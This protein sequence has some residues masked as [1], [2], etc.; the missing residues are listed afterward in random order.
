MP[1]KIKSMAILL[2]GIFYFLLLFI[3]TILSARMVLMTAPV[4]AP[5]E[6]ISLWY[7]LL[8][9]ALVTLFMLLLVRR[10]KTRLPFE[11]FFT[12]AIFAGI[13]FLADI[14]LTGSLG[15]IAAAAVMLLKYIY[16]R[17]WWQ[18]LV[19]ILGICGIVVSVGLSIP[20]LTA[21]IILVVL[22]F[23]DIV[24]VYFTRHMVEL[25]KGLLERGVV[26]ALIL[27]VKI[28]AILGPVRNIRAGENVMLLGTGDLA[29]PAIMVSSLV[30][31]SVPQA[32]CAA[33]GAIIGFVLMQSI[34]LRQKRKRPMP[35][36]PPIAALTLIGFLLAYLFNL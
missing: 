36:L 17:V 12:L 34:F 18:N 8:M 29:L 25:F 14:W 19:M 3:L 4:Y 32:A 5:S 27:P 16:K 7:F 13:W 15:I 1:D 31:L 9:L 30:R 28:K 26:F 35:A 11:I 20:W 23:Y 6:P 2:G 24:A 33:A 22:S 10:V 21:L